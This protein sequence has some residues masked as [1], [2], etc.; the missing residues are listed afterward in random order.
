M[1]DSIIIFS[2]RCPVGTNSAVEAIR[3][4][5]GLVALGEAV[6]TKV[7]LSGDGVLLMAKA[8]DPKAVEQ[9]TIDSAMEMAELS[10]LEIYIV[11]EA[12]ADAGMQQEDLRSYARLNIVSQA[13]FSS[14]V[15]EATTTFRL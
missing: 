15:S 7:V 6:P 9:D 8:A 12:L 2:D 5:A 10:D 3:M 13:E 4:G 14:M 11:K 1:V